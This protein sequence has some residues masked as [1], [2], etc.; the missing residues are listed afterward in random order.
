MKYKANFVKAVTGRKKGYIFVRSPEEINL[1]ELFEII[2]GGPLFDDCFL[3]H[4]ECGGTLENCCIFAIWHN[5]T[6]QINKLLKETTIAAATWSH[7]Q[8]RFLSLP[9]SLAKTKDK[10]KTNLINFETATSNDEPR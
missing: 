9:I 2:E 1:L 5:T 3:K 10:W 7:P 4:C 6:R 8:H